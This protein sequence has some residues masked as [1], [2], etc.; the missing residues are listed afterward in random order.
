MSVEVGKMLC[1]LLHDHIALK[2]SFPF[3]RRKPPAEPKTIRLAGLEITERGHKQRSRSFCVKKTQITELIG[4][5]AASV[6]FPEKKQLTVN[7]GCFGR[8]SAAV[9]S[10]KIHS[11]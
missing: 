6:M 10:K 8:D 7:L 4:A 11:Y 3:N 2:E 9:A 1:R 5:R